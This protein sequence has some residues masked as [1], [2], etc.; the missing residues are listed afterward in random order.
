MSSFEAVKQLYLEAIELA[1][2]Q[3]RAKDSES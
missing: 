3:L 1:L 2:T